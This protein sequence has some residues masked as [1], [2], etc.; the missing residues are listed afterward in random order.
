MQMM[1]CINLDTSSDFLKTCTVRESG[2][3]IVKSDIHVYSVHIGISPVKRCS[4]YTM[5]SEL[6]TIRNDLIVLN[7]HISS[8]GEP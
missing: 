4:F 7:I 8:Y 6:E 1:R 5:L 3:L 2:L